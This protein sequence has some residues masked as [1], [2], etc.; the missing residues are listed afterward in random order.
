MMRIAFVFYRHLRSTSNGIPLAV[1][2]QMQQEAT[3][4]TERIGAENS[5][6]AVG[7]ATHYA[8]T[9]TDLPESLASP[10]QLHCSLCFCLLGIE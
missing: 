4:K 10:L 3:E 9:H 5:L 6:Q 2:I 7:G 1:G 8:V